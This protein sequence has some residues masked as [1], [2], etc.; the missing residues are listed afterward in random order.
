MS[1][2]DQG[3]QDTVMKRFFPSRKM[4]RVWQRGHAHHAEATSDIADDTDSFCAG[5]S[6]HAKLGHLP[7]DAFEQKS[8]I[9]QPIGGCEVT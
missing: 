9:T 6:L 7:P 1:R 8:A 3:W 5:V 4:S 2:K